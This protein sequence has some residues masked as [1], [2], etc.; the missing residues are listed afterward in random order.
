MPRTTPIAPGAHIELRDAV[1]RVLRLDVTSTGRRIVRTVSAQ[2]G[3]LM[4]PGQIVPTVSAQFGGRFPAAARGSASA[5]PEFRGHCPRNLVGRPPAVTAGAEGRVSDGRL[6][7]AVLRS[8]IVTRGGVLRVSGGLKMLHGQIVRTV[9][10]QFTGR[11]TAPVSTD[12][13]PGRLVPVGVYRRKFLPLG[14]GC[15]IK[16]T[17]RPGEDKY[18]QTPICYSVG[19][20]R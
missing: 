11:F 16:K 12:H 15:P 2:F 19:R 4:L 17:T 18:H 14:V 9:S 20:Y 3:R 7:R 10:A 8:V 13:R 1:W 5:D 6:R